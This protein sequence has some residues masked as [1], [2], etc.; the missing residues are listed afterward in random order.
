MTCAKARSCGNGPATNE[1]WRTFAVRTVCHMTDQ[2]AQPRGLCTVR[3][4][5]VSQTTGTLFKPLAYFR[6]VSLLITPWSGA[7]AP[8]AARGGARFLK[9]L[10]PDTR[11]NSKRQRVNKSSGSSSLNASLHQSMLARE[12][13]ILM[14]L[15]MPRGPAL[16]GPDGVGNRCLER[17]R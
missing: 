3:L 13:L 12:G 15:M 14:M 2:R 7:S 6:V 10:V 11:R 1:H 16:R 4:L 17:Y 9:K 8:P 5:R